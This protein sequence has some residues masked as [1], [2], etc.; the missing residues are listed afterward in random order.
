MVK[1]KL[2]VMIRINTNQ[3]L[4]E[5]DNL[6]PKIKNAINEQKRRE[7][8]GKFIKVPGALGNLHKFIKNTKL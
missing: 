7:K 6:K 1:R 2:Q 4:D 8:Y 5:L 3:E